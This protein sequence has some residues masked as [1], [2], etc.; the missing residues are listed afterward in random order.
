MSK[1]LE[2]KFGSSFF[3]KKPDPNFSSKQV[4]RLNGIQNIC[5]VHAKS[6]RS[7]WCDG[8]LSQTNFTGLHYCLKGR[9][10]CFRLRHF[11]VIYNLALINNCVQKR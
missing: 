2:E 8:Q 6:C 3:H 5:R 11:S 9:G 10:S 7:H 1:S 4:A